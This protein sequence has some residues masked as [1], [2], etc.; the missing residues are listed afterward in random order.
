M[1]RLLKTHHNQ[2]SNFLRRPFLGQTLP[3]HTLQS[4]SLDD[5]KRLFDVTKVEMRTRENNTML[6]NTSIDRDEAT[7]EG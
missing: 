2:P 4:S 1:S 3:L 5:D 6:T 7:S